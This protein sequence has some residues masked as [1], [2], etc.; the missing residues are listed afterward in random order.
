[1]IRPAGPANWTY[2]EYVPSGEFRPR[3]IRATELVWSDLQN[4]YSGNKDKRG[5]INWDND[6]WWGE[7]PSDKLND[8]IDLTDCSRKIISSLALL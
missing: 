4:P 6:N 1:M 8:I 2:S 3:L 5:N 7:L